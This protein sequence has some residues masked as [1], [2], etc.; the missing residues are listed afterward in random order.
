[1][2]N[3]KLIY[4]IGVCFGEDTLH[5]LKEG[6]NVIGVEANV[7][8]HKRNEK[9]FRKYIK[10]GSLILVNKGITNGNEKKT[11]YYNKTMPAFSSFDKEQ[12]VKHGH[13]QIIELEVETTTI[14]DLFNKYGVPY[15]LKS[16]IEGYDLI[17]IQSLK[18]NLKPTYISVEAKPE[19]FDEILSQLIKLGYSKFKIINQYTHLALTNTFEYEHKNLSL[20]ER[21]YQSVK[22]NSNIIFKVLRFLKAE[23]ILEHI[24][25]IRKELTFKLGS[26]GTFAEATDGVW[27]TA[28][29]IRKIFT[30]TYSHYIKNKKSEYQDYWADLHAK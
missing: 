21:F 15:Y 9:L 10:N 18:S 5:Y 20:V 11:F 4:D 6:H 1:M 29:E 30:E 3:E 7:Y 24:F 17:V 14:N 8:L 22:Y 23:L 2:K 27:S 16:D 19:I 12:S 26:S 28:D 25:N 13:N